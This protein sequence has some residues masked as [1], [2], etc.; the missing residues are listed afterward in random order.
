[1]LKVEDTLIIVTDNEK[2]FCS[3]AYCI[4]RGTEK[5]DS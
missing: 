2:L 4:L 3:D 1:M 5:V